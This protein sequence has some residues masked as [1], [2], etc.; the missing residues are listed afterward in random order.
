MAASQ[1]YQ[2]GS[3]SFDSR[4]TAAM[5][6]TDAGSAVMPFGCSPNRLPSMAAAM[7]KAMT[8]PIHASQPASG[9]TGDRIM[10]SG[11]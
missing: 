11:A 3:S 7:A 8:S 5:P 10:A 6:S 9:R 4:I 1:R 2:R